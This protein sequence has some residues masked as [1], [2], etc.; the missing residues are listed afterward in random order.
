MSQQ[1]GRVTIKLD[2]E[3]FRSKPGAEMQLGGI[4]RSFDA[5]DQGS[6]YY[7]EKSIPGQFKF[8]LVHM[9]DSDLAKLNR[10]KNGTAQY[11]TDTGIVYTMTNAATAKVGDLKNGEV[12]VTIG[13]D[14]V[15]Q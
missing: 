1:T 12:E 2:G 5:D 4:E 14:T 15:C 6:S 9:G 7:Q 10:W 11:E 3:P 8:T 13:G